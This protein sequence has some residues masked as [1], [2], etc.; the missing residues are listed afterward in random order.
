[1]TGSID[2]ALVSRLSGEFTA[3][4]TRMGALGRDL[5]VLHR[6]VL[7]DAPA[8]GSSSGGA[9]RV[10]G[11]VPPPGSPTAGGR[12]ASTGPAAPVPAPPSA[13]HAT[14]PPT[15]PGTGSTPEGWSSSSVEPGGSPST[16][17]VDAAVAAD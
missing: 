16:G 1:M 9:T 2:P 10:V 14:A 6:Q 8:A 3:L 7:A 5:E 17:A 4:G 13:A 12:D 11:D 15:V